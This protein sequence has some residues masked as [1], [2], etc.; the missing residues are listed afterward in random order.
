M[1][2]IL[3]GLVWSLVLISSC[4][5]QNLTAT[6]ETPTAPQGGTTIDKN[7]RLDND[8]DLVCGMSLALGVGDTAHYEDKLFG[9][10]SK[11]CKDKFA[12]NPSKY[13]AAK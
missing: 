10:C 9:F 6:K 7:I 11:G 4:Y 2:P 3:F 1:R 13:I 8:R 12:K 5:R